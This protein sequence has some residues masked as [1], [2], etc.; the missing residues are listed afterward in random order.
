MKKAVSVLLALVLVQ[1]FSAT[2][3]ADYGIVVTGHPADETRMEGETAWFV[4][5]AK[6]YTTS[7]WSFVDPSGRTYTAEEFRS[8][9]PSVIVEGEHTTM[10]TVG[11][12]NMDLNGWAVFCSF[13]SSGDNASTNWAFFHVD[14]CPAPAYT[15][16]SYAPPAYDYY[17]GDTTYYWEGIS[18][19][20]Y[21][22]EMMYTETDGAMSFVGIDGSYFFIGSDGL[23][24]SFD[25]ASGSFEVGML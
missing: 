18:L 10:L 23:W 11:N 8:V 21:S 20:D 9:F 6:Y 12:L 17:D 22:D 13:H 5:S 1:A 25:A 2:A 3:F 4:S 7:D 24:E 16:P 15:V 19:T 14:A